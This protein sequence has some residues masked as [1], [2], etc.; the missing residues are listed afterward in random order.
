MENADSRRA[1]SQSLDLEHADLL[2]KA[3]LFAGL[4]RVTLA[5]LAARLES[6]SVP[7][8]AELFR[9]LVHD[10]ADKTVLG[11]TGNFD[12]DAVLDI[13]LAQPQTAEFIVAKL[14]RGSSARRRRPRPAA[15]PVPP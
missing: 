13:L 14:R 11:R 4:D 3:K 12:G 6:V 10:D 1:T 2:A 8:G 7:G 5:K 15:P 9:P